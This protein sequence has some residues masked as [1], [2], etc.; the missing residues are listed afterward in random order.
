[1]VDQRHSQ[2]NRPGVRD[3]GI[4]VRAARR[5]RSRD[6]V[7]RQA[8]RRGLFRG[9]AAH[10]SDGEGRRGWTAGRTA[11]VVSRCQYPLGLELAPTARCEHRPVLAAM[12]SRPTSR[13]STMAVGA[14]LLSLEPLAVV[15]VPRND[16]RQGR[17]SSSRIAPSSIASPTSEASLGA[18]VMLPLGS[19]SSA[20]HLVSGTSTS[21][22]TVLSG[23]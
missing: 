3:R 15:P 23:G 14:R 16:R 21:D 6:T 5:P 7:D 18:F 2:R 8:R 19:S 20:L 4:G 22:P 12:T 17:S 10:M 13:T 1:M 9:R 11:H